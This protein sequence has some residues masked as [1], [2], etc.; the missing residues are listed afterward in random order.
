MRYFLMLLLLLAAGRAG[1]QP[2]A[3]LTARLDKVSLTFALG[4]DGRP[5]YAVAYGLKGG[6][7]ALAAG[8]GTGGRGGL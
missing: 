1:A 7:A 6:A 4:A 8:A 3:P 5:G 2:A